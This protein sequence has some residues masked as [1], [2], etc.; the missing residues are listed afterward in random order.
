MRAPCRRRCATGISRGLNAQVV[1]QAKDRG[2]ILQPCDRLGNRDALFRGATNRFRSNSY[3]E[4]RA[5][6]ASPHRSLAGLRRAK[7]RGAV[8]PASAALIRAARHVPPAVRRRF[9]AYLGD[10]RSSGPR[11][12][13]RHCEQQ[14]QPAKE[15]ASHCSHSTPASV[16]VFNLTAAGSRRTR[17]AR[18]HCLSGRSSCHRPSRG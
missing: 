17:C 2:P 14:A 5:N 7:P 6:G 15:Q 9:S 13:Q 8:F 4:R 3:L 18:R 10:K 11:G 12:A 1:F 16:S